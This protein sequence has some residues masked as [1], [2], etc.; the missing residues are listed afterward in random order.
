MEHHEKELVHIVDKISTSESS[1]SS[2]S[3]NAGEALNTIEEESD[4]KR[5]DISRLEAIVTKCAEQSIVK[6][7]FPLI[8]KNLEEIVTKDQTAKWLEQYSKLSLKP[9][10]FFEIPDD[11]QCMMDCSSVTL[12]FTRTAAPL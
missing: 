2:L 3:T 11:H 8:L 9:Q 5:A 4:D 6:N 1:T 7:L 12:L 10:S